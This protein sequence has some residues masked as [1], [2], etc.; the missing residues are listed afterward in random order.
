MSFAFDKRVIGKS[1]N[2]QLD[3]LAGSFEFLF[4]TVWLSGC[5]AGCGMLL[6][7]LVVDFSWLLLLF[8]I[9]FFAGWFFGVLYLDILPIGQRAIDT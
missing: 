3:G 7:G 1:F 2:C 5:S 4:M 9:P 6:R 8:S